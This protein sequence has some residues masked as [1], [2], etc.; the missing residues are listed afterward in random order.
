MWL[1]HIAPDLPITITLAEVPASTYISIIIIILIIF[2]SII[3]I[4][5]LTI[6]PSTAQ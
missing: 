3:F 4:A 1:K 2:I 5:T 6:I